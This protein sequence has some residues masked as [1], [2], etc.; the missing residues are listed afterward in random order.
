L[1]RFRFFGK[2]PDAERAK[3]ELA[4]AMKEVQTGEVRVPTVLR[5][6]GEGKTLEEYYVESEGNVKIRIRIAEIVRPD[7]QIERVCHADEPPLT[8]LDEILYVKTFRAIFE[9]MDPEKVLRGFD[10]SSFFRENL[11]KVASR[12]KVNLTNEQESKLLY[13]LTREILKHSILEPFMLDPNIEDIKVVRPGYPV[14][15]VHRS[16]SAYGWLLTNAV[17]T[18]PKHLDELIIRFARMGRRPINPAQPIADFTTEEGVRI[19][20]AL[21]K[22]VTRYGPALSIRKFPI[23]ITQLIQQNVLSPL[24]AA[25]MWFIL[26]R[27]AF[28]FI[29]G[30]TGSGKTTLLNALLGLIDPHKT[31]HTIEEVFEINPPT[32]R[33]VGFTTKRSS[34]T[35]GVEIGIPDMLKLNLRMRPDYLVVDEIRTARDLKAFLDVARTG[36][37]GLATINAPDL[38]HLL[39]RL[40]DT[41]IDPATAEK[42]W[43]CAIIQVSPQGKSR[44]AV[45]ADFMPKEHSAIEAVE[46]IKWEPSGDVFEPANPVELFMGSPRLKAYSKETG[47][48]GDEIV[49]ELAKKVD[50]LT[51]KVSSLKNPGKAKV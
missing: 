29:A 36:Q 27:K 49:D 20:A 11:M 24:M 47:V 22:A 42:L 33:Y 25:Y 35:S 50:E 48:S 37:S 15:V 6:S 39:M 16:Y 31:V 9:L 2:A 19:A 3:E 41:R 18:D 44:V 21:G 13:Y 32:D 45:I 1:P 10:P 34:E 12:L 43:G 40:E 38:E 23:S 30:P 28:F 46:V 5:D 8:T 4:K 26:E 17:F 7:G 14:L 51:K